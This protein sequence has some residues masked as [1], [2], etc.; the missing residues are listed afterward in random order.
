MVAGA[1]RLA[2]ALEVVFSLVFDPSLYPLSS[3][4]YRHHV[5]V[6]HDAGMPEDWINDQLASLR[7]ASS[8]LRKRETVVWICREGLCT[9][10]EASG[11][12]PPGMFLNARAAAIWLG[13]RQPSTVLVGKNGTTILKALGPV[14]VEEILRQIDHAPDR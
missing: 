7:A 2:N 13:I 3:H 14:T 6:L 4:R 5:V 11:L 10:D 12:A 8:E 9:L 1:R